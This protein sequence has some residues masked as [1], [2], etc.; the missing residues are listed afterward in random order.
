MGN[1]LTSEEV[2]RLSSLFTPLL[3]NYSEEAEPR[4][5]G[6]YDLLGMSRQDAFR[7]RLLQDCREDVTLQFNQ[8]IKT[9]NMGPPLGFL[10]S[11]AS[12]V[13]VNMK[14]VEEK[15]S[16]SRYN[17]I[18]RELKRSRIRSLRRLG[19]GL[20]RKKA[21]TLSICSNAIT[22]NTDN[23]SQVYA[24]GEDSCGNHAITV[25]GQR[26][27]RGRVEYLILNSQSLNCR[28][29]DEGTTARRFCA[30]NT[31]KTWI[32]EGTL[33]RITYKAQYY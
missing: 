19:R 12:M 11:I 32:D 14:K 2:S 25:I 4:S 17:R 27:R 7:S 28:I 20:R 30:E 6:I 31:G 16:P 13:N 33:S 1:G 15:L 21:F 24:G 9:E 23:D 10:D 29:Y 26:C 8:E 22:G 5:I 3:W 18:T